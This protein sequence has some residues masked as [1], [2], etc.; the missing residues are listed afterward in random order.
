MAYGVKLMHWLLNTLLSSQAT[1]THLNVLGFAANLKRRNLS[2][3]PISPP[4]VKLR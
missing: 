2:S 3:L 1:T 4:G